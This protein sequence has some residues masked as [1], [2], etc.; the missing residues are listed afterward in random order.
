M[1]GLIAAD[2]ENRGAQYLLALGIDQHFHEALSLAFFARP[3]DP[4]HRHLAHQDFRAGAL[5]FSLTHADTTERWV[6]E[7]TVDRDAIADLALRAIQKVVG[8]DLEVVIGGMRK[9]TAP[10]AVPQRVHI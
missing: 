3:R 9:G 7:K 6:C 1:H 10:I 4:S 8:N 2:A 5:G